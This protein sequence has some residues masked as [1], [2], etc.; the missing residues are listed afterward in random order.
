MKINEVSRVLNAKILSTEYLSCEIKSIYVSDLM[1]DVLT[2]GRN[3]QLL[4][5]SLTNQQTIRTV[6]MVEIPAIIYTNGKKP[7]NETIELA[8]S[9]EITILVTELS[10]FQVTG[11]LFAA[12]L[13]G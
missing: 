5:T 10:T 6:E 13:Q 11:K 4:V 1:S 8:K 3:A 7:G 12:G 2:Y 9:N